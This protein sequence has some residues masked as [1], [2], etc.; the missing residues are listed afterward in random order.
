M[1]LLEIGSVNAGQLDCDCVNAIIAI[2]STWL[3]ACGANVT[4]CILHVVARM[5]FTNVELL[6]LTSV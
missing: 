6:A 3:S 2:A 4:A 1:L 5:F